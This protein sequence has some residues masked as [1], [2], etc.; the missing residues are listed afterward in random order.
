MSFF[1]APS[2]FTNFHKPSKDLISLYYSGITRRV[3]STLLWLYSPI[4]IYIL[5]AETGMD[6]SLSIVFVLLYFT[7]FTIA[8]LITLINAEDLSRNLGFKKT[9][10]ISIIPALLYIASMVYAQDNLI[11]L[12]PASL[13]A[14]M[15]SGWYWWGYHG[16][17]IKS[18]KKDH[19]G[20]SIAQFQLFETLISIITPIFGGILITYF[21]YMSLF[22]VSAMFI[23]ISQ[24]LLGKD[25]EKRQ[26][27]DI[28]FSNIVSLVFRHKSISLAYIGSSAESTIYMVIWPII[29]Y[30]YFGEMIDLGGI[31]TAAI[32]IASVIGVGIGSWVD[33]HGERKA[34]GIGTPLVFLS[35]IT[36]LF[37]ANPLLFVFADTLWNL[38]QKFVGLPLN[39]LTYRKATTADGTASAIMFREIEITIGAIFILLSSIILII[40]KFEINMIFVL[41]SFVSVWPIIAVIKKRLP[42]NG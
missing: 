40:L 38:G 30:L 4:F 41:A 14:G 5:F 16:Y 19:F 12:L 42:E 13:F 36:R 25:H 39:A 7:L 2:V 35:W 31:V 10:K 1:H 26:R 17:F 23:V 37:S 18:E 34:V 11:F 3:S 20:E 32:F 21:G 9:I 29:L 27:K 6:S 28:K 15:Y 24:Y 8:K 22:G 33:K